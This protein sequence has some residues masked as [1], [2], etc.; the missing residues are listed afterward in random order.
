MVKSKRLV[1]KNYRI[2]RYTPLLLLL[3]FLLLVAGCI[4]E[5]IP[6]TGEKNELVVVEGMVTDLNES[7]TVK[8]SKSVPLGKKSEVK[9]FSGCIVSISDDLGNIFNLQENSP[10]IYHTNPAQF[11]GVI[12]RSYTLHVSASVS[13]R[14]FHYESSPEKLKAVPPIDS[15][16]YEKTVIAPATKD[17]PMIN[18]CQIYLNTHDPT[19]SCKF[20][21]W[22]FSETWEIRLHWPVDHQ[23][24]WVTENSP[25]INLKNT[26][27]FAESTVRHFPINFVSNTTDRLVTKYSINV[28]QYSLNEDEFLYWEKIQN[29]TQQVG[30]LYDIVPSS[31]QGNMQCIENPDESVLGY[32]SV[33]SRSSKRIFIKDYFS[34]LL[35]PYSDFICIYKT[36]PTDFPDGYPGYGTSVWALLIQIGSFTT[37][38]YTILTKIHACA[39]CTVRGSAIRPDFW[40][41]DK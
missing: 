24:C 41:G 7:Y 2:A 17:F 21:R 19:D 8:V 10:G 32:F 11:R 9:P 28:N 16:F 35:D 12:G 31:V 13:N 23:I 26:S 25:L 30:G 33:S 18:G 6:V 4:T 38:P 15:L 36:I 27:G 37:K 3:A 20:Y 22:D 40:T 29:I 34:G 1:Q 14:I 39:D 5:F